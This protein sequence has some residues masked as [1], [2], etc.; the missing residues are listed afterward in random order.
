MIPSVLPSSSTP[1]QRARSQ[2]P[3]L[4]AAWAWGMLRAS[5]TSRP[6][7][8]SAAE[9]TVDSGAFATTIPCR[10]AASTST[11][12]IPTPARAITFSRSARS[13]RSAVSRV[14]DLITIASY[15]S[16]ICS[17]G[18][19]SST[20]TSK[21]VRSNSRPASAIGSRTRTRI[22]RRSR[23]AVRRPRGRCCVARLDVDADR[24]E[25]LLDG[26]E[27][28]G[29][30]VDRDVADVADAEQPRHE[31][32][33]PAGD[34][35]PVPV[36]E[37]EPQRDRVD[38]LRG[39]RRGEDGGAVLVGRVELE[40]QRL[41][42]GPAGSSDRK[43]SREA[44]LET[45]LE[46][47]AQRRSQGDDSRRGGREQRRALR[48][49]L[50]QL[51]PVP[52]EARQRRPRPRPRPLGNRRKRETRWSHERL[53]RARDDDVRAPAVGL[54][55]H[56]TEAGDGVHDRQ[57]IGGAA[58]GE[59][60]LEVADDARRGLGVDEH[61]DLRATRVERAA[62][63]R[64]P[65]ASRPTGNRAGRRRDRRRA[66]APASACR[67]HRSTRRARARPARAG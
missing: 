51:L 46:Q 26:A 58:R 67:T 28:D 8:C 12:S 54:E 40:P 34:R 31:L 39:E 60:S 10:V 55:R 61:H 30:V 44:G 59:Q 45:V 50:A 25:L 16:R 53:L 1:L 65:A 15:R 38:T 49:G 37:R 41:D 22:V 17:S 11:L 33:V 56:G 42:A 66:P 3:S 32:T 13:I 64:R 52:V 47:Y 7:V 23:G 24:G 9:T 29:D 18:D 4:S 35:D 43:V 21:C 36:A 14:A 48:L 63:G 5:A 57:R 19:S 6:I 27:R 2:R 62:P 20:S